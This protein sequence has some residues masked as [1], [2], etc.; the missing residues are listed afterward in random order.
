M[1]PRQRFFMALTADRL[2]PAYSVNY[3]GFRLARNSVP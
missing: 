1:M 2:Y 3:L